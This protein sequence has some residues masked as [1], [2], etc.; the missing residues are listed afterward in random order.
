MEPWPT[1]DEITTA[2]ILGHEPE[3]G[4][5]GCG[6]KVKRPSGITNKHQVA[7]HIWTVIHEAKRDRAKRFGEYLCEP[8][9]GSGKKPLGKGSCP[10]CHGVG[11]QSKIPR[12]TAIEI[13]RYRNH[14]PAGLHQCVCGADDFQLW[15]E[16]A[17]RVAAGVLQELEDFEKGLAHGGK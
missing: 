1:Q 13:A 9:K 8:C 11:T 17:R 4:E 6:F 5:C 2:R 10:T 7:N 14:E 3:A 12:G 15:H 16:H